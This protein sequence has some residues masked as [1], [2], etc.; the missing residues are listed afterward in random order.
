M[1]IAGACTG[2]LALTW[3]T[4]G[5]ASAGSAEPQVESIRT[6]VDWRDISLPLDAYEMPL[7]DR[8]QILSAEFLLTAQCMS[9][10]GLHL[11]GPDWGTLTPDVPVKTMHYRLYGLI[12]SE[13]AIRYGYHSPAEAEKTTEQRSSDSIPGDYSNVLGAKL[14]GGE[15]DGK[16]IPEG[17]CIGLA[18]KE[19]EG[20]ISGQNSLVE[21]LRFRS[22][23]AGS[24]DSRV[25]TAFGAWSS[26]MAEA[27]FSYEKPEDANND[28]AFSG[29]DFSRLE[30]DVAVSDVQCKKKT[31]LIGI[32]T[33]VE[34]AY[35]E[36]EIRL[37]AAD[38]ARLI[39]QH[40]E[41][42]DRARKVL[43]AN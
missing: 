5:I 6:I 31:N 28:A 39:K 12:D 42:I 4:F 22:W 8:N 38:L 25:E 3:T 40:D 10:F 21:E 26:C 9:G 2:A 18:R 23:T 33:A 36:E 1:I 35:Q 11:D 34:S 32:R 29:T 16:L 37:H 43:L 14:G 20:G 15:F 24:R 27:G 7:T 41:A 13:H 19:V 30:I 17:G